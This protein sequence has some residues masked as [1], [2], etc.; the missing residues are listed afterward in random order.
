[1]RAIKAEAKRLE[2]LQLQYKTQVTVPGEGDQN[3]QQEDMEINE[4]YKLF[5]N[6]MEMEE[7]L[8]RR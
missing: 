3:I 4:R 1:M 6:E 7:E 2:E 8:K 5:L